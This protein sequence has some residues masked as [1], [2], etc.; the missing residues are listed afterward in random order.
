[1]D[2]GLREQYEI[3]FCADQESESSPVQGD[4]ALLKRAL[5]NLIQNSIVHNPQGCRIS[6]SVLCGGAGIMVEVVDDGAGVSSE[7]LEELT[8]G[9]HRLESTDEK[10]NLRHG[11]GILLVRQI[12]EAHKGTVTMESEPQKGFKTALAFPVSNF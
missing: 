7:K 11:L 2:S 8:A 1:L 6:V 10:L 9:G 12:M 3:E 5:S 4:E